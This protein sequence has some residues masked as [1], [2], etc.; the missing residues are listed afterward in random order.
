MQGCSSYE[1]LLLL[2][3]ASEHNP[4]NNSI[5]VNNNIIIN[6]FDVVRV[7]RVNNRSDWGLINEANNNVNDARFWNAT[8]NV[9]KKK[10]SIPGSLSIRAIYYESSRG[11]EAWSTMS[12]DLDG[13]FE[14]KRNEE[15]AENYLLEE[16]MDNDTRK[17]KYA[18]T[19]VLMALTRA[20]DTSYIEINNNDSVFAKC[21]EEFLIKYPDYTKL[22]N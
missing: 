21:I 1:S 9:D 8:G 18:A 10:Q 6:E 16:I 12:F 13:F 14:A 5:G 17:D 3:N 19:W 11:L 15:E 22:V 7:N 4:E 20:I 2:K